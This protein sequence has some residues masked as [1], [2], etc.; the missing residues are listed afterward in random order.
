VNSPV[1][2]KAVCAGVLVAGATVGGGLLFS[3]AASGFGWPLSYVAAG[4]ALSFAMAVAFC[5]GQLRAS[6]AIG[7]FGCIL[8]PSLF[9][10]PACDGQMMMWPVVGAVLGF[11]VGRN[12]DRVRNRI[13]AR[14]P[15]NVDRY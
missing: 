3:T 5:Y 1:V 12:L 6:V 11:I 4:A 13:V 7:C 15:R 10:A 14:K 2:I 8:Q 9:V